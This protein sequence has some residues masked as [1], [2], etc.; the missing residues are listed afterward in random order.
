ME[1]INGYCIVQCN[2][3]AKSQLHGKMHICSDHSTRQHL[4]ARNGSSSMTK[5]PLQPFNNSYSYAAVVSTSRAQLP[6][7]GIVPTH[8][9]K[10]TEQYCARKAR[11]LSLTLKK[12]HPLLPANSQTPNNTHSSKAQ[13]PPSSLHTCSLPNI[14]P[15]KPNTKGKMKLK[16][17]SL[18]KSAFPATNNGA[19]CSLPAAQ[20]QCDTGKHPVT[21]SITNQV[22]P[23]NPTAGTC[24]CTND[25]LC[26]DASSKGDI[27]IHEEVTAPLTLD[28]RSNKDP[29]LISSAPSTMN[30]VLPTHDQ[31][32]NTKER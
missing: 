4:L 25:G 29:Q 27:Q 9:H 13:S 23:S 24:S 16:G 5:G 22:A 12:P 15:H 32:H 17:K 18:I 6:N 11:K 31:S 10:N 14:Q 30:D 7:T 2:V 26:R 19:S 3:I 21:P 20:T 8:S 1:A 28:K